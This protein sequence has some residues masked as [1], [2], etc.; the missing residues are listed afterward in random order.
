MSKF[1]PPAP[2]GYLDPRVE[3]LPP[4]PAPETDF[5]AR[6]DGVIILV[7][8]GDVYLA[9]ACCAS[10]RQNMGNIPITLLVDRPQTN[11]AEVERLPQVK[12]L[13][14]QDVMDAETARLCTGFWVKL[15]VF[16]VSP[17][18]RF[19]YLDAD[20]LVWGDV[21]AQAD[22]D[23]FD[24]Q[25]A[26]D[27]NRPR[28]F[29]TAEDIQK[30][31]YDLDF[32]AKQ[33]PGLDW[34]GM[35]LA[36]NGVFFARRGVFSRER[37]LA[38]RQWPCWRNY[39]QGVLNYLRW[40]ALAAGHPRVGGQR[41]QILPAES[42]YRPE[43]RYLPRDHRRPAV[44]HWIGKKPKIGR[45]YRAA[46]D[47]RKLFLKMTGRNRWLTLRLFLEDVAVWLKRQRRSVNRRLGKDANSSDLAAPSSV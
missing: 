22:F 16:W 27:F 3:S 7:S 14:A 10:I 31:V 4:P 8:A 6:L 35:E 25:A 39:E 36:N 41:L 19:L 26:F 33:N 17:Y 23:Q 45:R 30:Y 28:V 44:I 18:E 21:R 13:V 24:F 38:L 40:E 11:T 42:P 9:K 12:R 5:S 1:S 32:I 43:D 34:R 20:T 37:L 46:D 47:Y 29:D 2:P 15:L